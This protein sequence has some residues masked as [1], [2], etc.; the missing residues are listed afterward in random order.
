MIS[1]IA[2]HRMLYV[3]IG[4]ITAVAAI[5]AIVVIPPSTIPQSAVI[6]IWVNVIVHL[7]IIVALIRIIKVNKRGDLLVLAGVALII[8]SLLMLDGVFAYIGTPDQHS[9]GI[10]LMICVGCDFVAGLL[11]IIARYI[12]RP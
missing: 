6:P 3:G 11:T 7:L 5:L 9:V 4:L 2:W 1:E 8:L 12:R 10:S